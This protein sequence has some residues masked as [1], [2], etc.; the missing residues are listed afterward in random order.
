MGFGAGLLKAV[1]AAGKWIVKNP[2][3]VMSAVDQVKD[4]IV[5]GKA[6]KELPA[7]PQ[8]EAEKEQF[9]E[10]L[11]QLTLQMETKLTRLWQE[12][13]QEKKRREQLE[14]KVNALQKRLTWV[15][16]LSLVGVVAA[17]IIGCLV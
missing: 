4:R 13:E 6:K 10:A 14:A 17:V 1:A 3:T 5:A 12:L 16:A 8:A 2:G 9:S 7:I 15:T 11:Q